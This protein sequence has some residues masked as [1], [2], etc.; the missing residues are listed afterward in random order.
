MRRIAIIF[1]HK[2]GLSDK[3]SEIKEYYAKLSTREY[4][5]EISIIDNGYEIHDVARKYASGE[6]DVIVAAGGDGTISAVAEVLVG[7]TNTLGVLPLGTL[8]HFAKDMNIPLILADA[9][10]LISTG[11]RIIKIDVAKC[12]NT[13]FINNSSIGIYPKV[14][15]LR[16]R[17]Q[18]Q[19]AQKWMAFLSASR[20]VL[21]QIPKIS[22]MLDIDGKRMVRKT[23]F[24]FVGNN[25]YKLEG[26]NVGSRTM[27]TGGRLSLWVSQNTT[28]IGLLLLGIRMLFGKTR[29]DRDFSAFYPSEIEVTTK[30]KDTLVSLDGEVAQMTSPLRYSIVPNSLSVLV[31]ELI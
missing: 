2:S 13:V 12:N 28:S 23:S 16:E 7:S 18:E 1:N 26:L 15:A 22:I 4:F 31:S 10:D 19:G 9:L 3:L 17:F 25:R 20:S 30:E 21:R 8:N 5:V 11:R 6:W 27:L 24:I 14:V 29:E